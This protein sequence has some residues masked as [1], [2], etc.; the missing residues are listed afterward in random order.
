ML[1][2]IGRDIPPP[3]LRRI[4]ERS[5]GVPLFVEE[6]ARL[7]VQ[8]DRADMPATLHDLLTAR[9][10]KLGEAKRIAQLAA[11]I[12]REFDED[13]L[14]R[15]YPGDPAALAQS[16]SALQDAGLIF[17][18]DETTRQFKHALIQE[19]ACQSMTKADRQ[20]AHRRIAQTL[21]NDFPDAAATQPEVIAQHFAAAGET[22]PA[23]TYWVKAGQRAV[24]GSA[25]LEAAGHFCNG[26]RLLTA[27]PPGQERDRLEAVLQINLGTTLIA[28]RGYGSVEAG[29]S[30]AR[31]L[32][33]CKKGSD[34]VGVYRALWGMWLTS[35]S[36]IGHA[37]SLELAE[38]LLH[39]AQQT[40]D[41]LQLQ[42]AH[43]AMGNS[44]LMTG[45]PAAARFHL[46]QS[47][48]LYH[49]SHHDELVSQYG[50][51]VCVSGISLLSW[52]LWLQGL[53][54]QAV[55]ASQ[56]AIS[57]ARQIGYPYS[58][59]YAL[60]AAATFHRWMGQVEMTGKLA[61]EAV[62]LSHKHGLP[63]WLGMGATAQGWTLAMQGQ[64]TG[65][66]QIRQCLDAVNAIMNGALILFLAPLCEALVHLGQFDDALAAVNQSLDVASAKEDRFLESEFLRLKGECLLGISANNAEEAEACF[67]QALAISRKQGAKSLELRATT[68]LAQHFS[69]GGLLSGIAA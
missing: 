61:Q 13:L 65:I 52:V 38:K 47:I 8:N 37:H 22:R 9:M 39:L 69:G 62:A 11:T 57:L 15:I 19:A 46:E 44:S 53:P 66:E 30:Y 32:E 45:N 67:A 29:E 31:A 16:L 28:T 50:E 5:D 34:S 54:A 3:L 55:A 27:L 17:E 14:R 36:R 2:S 4:V 63:F 7:A 20:D 48:A 23:I 12:G 1:S 60:C 64:P 21:Q 24:R 43:H 25:N 10:N 40:N 51:N 59:G 56:H 68:S 6:M 18:I 49:P 33:L 58:L 42:S 41:I 35:S 26:L